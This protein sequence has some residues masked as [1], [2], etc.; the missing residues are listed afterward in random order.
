MRRASVHGHSQPFIKTAPIQAWSSFSSRLLPD[1]PG[2]AEA[3]A[4]VGAPGGLRPGK[5]DFEVH[6]LPQLMPE[7]SEPSAPAMLELILLSCTTP[8][9]IAGEL[10]GVTYSQ[11][12]RL[13]ITT[14][15][16]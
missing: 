8:W 15:A 1:G 2:S 14:S 7:I 11:V 10:P 12:P 3:V 5:F 4:A 13:I 6:T 16:N 9:D